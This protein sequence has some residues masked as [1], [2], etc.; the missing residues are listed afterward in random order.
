MGLGRSLEDKANSHGASKKPKKNKCK[1]FFFL[2][3]RVKEWMP[4]PLTV[5]LYR[6]RTYSSGTPLGTSQR[7]SSPHVADEKLLLGEAKPRTPSAPVG[8]RDCQ[9]THTSIC[10]PLFQCPFL[11]ISTALQKARPPRGGACRA[12]LN[13]RPIRNSQGEMTSSSPGCL[14]HG[15]WVVHISY[16]QWDDAKN[17][18][19]HNYTDKTPDFPPRPYSLSKSASSLPT[20]CCLQPLRPPLPLG[21]HNKSP[22]KLLF[23]LFL[24]IAERGP[25]I[26]WD[27]ITWLSTVSSP[28]ILKCHNY[29]NRKG[30]GVNNVQSLLLTRF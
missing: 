15:T 5:T 21:R 16:G 9:D 25:H 24:W 28:G 18:S 27:I 17:S 13:P 30:W 6:P 1:L 11:C 19:S 23:W 20:S 4:H 3:E 22:N 8:G 29:H 2:Y 10:W 12:R 7:Y 14:C 26:V